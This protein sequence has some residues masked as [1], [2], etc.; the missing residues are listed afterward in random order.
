MYILQE[1]SIFFCSAIG[2]A[3]SDN[4]SIF[5]E[6]GLDPKV[7]DLLKSFF[8]FNFKDLDYGFKY[9]GFQLKPNN[10]QKLDWHWLLKKIEKRIGH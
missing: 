6:F 3:I 10:Y 9:M 8:P 4:E 7:K 1:Y 5:L 2:M